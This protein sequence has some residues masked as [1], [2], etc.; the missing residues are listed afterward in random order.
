MQEIIKYQEIDAQLRKAEQ[1]LRQSLNKKNA[2]DMQQYLKDGQAKLMKLDESAKNLSAQYQKAVSLYNEFVSKLEA[3]AKKIEEAGVEKIA[4][5]EST[6]YNFGATAENLENNIVNL[7]NRINLVNKEVESIMNNAKKAKHNLEIYKANYNK[8]REKQEPIIN[9]LK[10]KLEKQKANVD[11][12]L[13]AK[14]NAKSDSNIF[15][16]FAELQ[17]GRCGK[18]KIEIPAGKISD[19][20]VKGIIECE[21]CGRLIYIK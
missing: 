3:L 9:A 19:L 16:V 20:K 15:P 12:K 17:N 1:E 4:E 2:S 8:E 21:H 10:E 18:C 14:Y 6:I 5:I 13:L 11:A 7:A